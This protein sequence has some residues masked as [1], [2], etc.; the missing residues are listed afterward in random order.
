MKKV[1]VIGGGFAGVE[2][3]ARLQKTFEVTL[4]D[5]KDYFECTVGAPK[6]IGNPSYLKGMTIP[7]RSIL[8]D[9]NIIAEGVAEVTKD[10]VVHGGGRVPFDYLC[11]ASGSGYAFP[12]KPETESDITKREATFKDVHQRLKEATGILVIGGGPVGVEVA[13]EIATKYRGKSLTIVESGPRLLSRLHKKAHD[14][15]RNF[16]LD[17]K[18]RLIFGEKIKETRMNTSVTDKGTEIEADVV[19]NCMGIKPNTDFLVPHFPDA[20]DDRKR[21][22]VNNCLQLEGYPHIFALGDCNNIQEEKLAINAKRH[23]TL[24]VENIIR[25]NQGM[26]PVPYTISKLFATLIGLGNREAIMATPWYA[27]GGNLP[28]QFKSAEVPLLMK[29][30]TWSYPQFIWKIY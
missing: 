1:V 16:F 14:Y 24:T 30:V 27:Y 21:V 7:Y 3:A 11:I 28:Y 29:T 22:K 13:S 9:T 23:A 17:K 2:V 20:L 12:I 25:V 5:M 8:R 6:A 18:A 4:I 26:K 15:A 10:E 19:F